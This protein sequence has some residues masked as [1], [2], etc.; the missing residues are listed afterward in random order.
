MTQ[1]A[2]ERAYEILAVHREDAAK[3]R[4]IAVMA[5]AVAEAAE[6]TAREAEARASAFEKE[7]DVFTAA[8]ESAEQAAYE[9]VYGTE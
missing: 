1:S 4:G 8:F 5:K 6:Q 2:V 3:A 7:A 9:A